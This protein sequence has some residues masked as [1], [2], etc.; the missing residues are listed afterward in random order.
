[1]DFDLKEAFW[2]ARQWLQKDWSGLIVAYLLVLI[3][4]F[5]AIWAVMEPFGIPA[6]VDVNRLPG[7]TK[8]RVFFHIILALIVSAYITLILELLCRRKIWTSCKVAYQ[9]HVEADA[10][11]GWVSDGTIAG[12]TGEDRRMEAIRIKLGQDVPPGMG[13]TYQAHVEG[14]GWTDW[15]SDGEDAGTTGLYKRLEAIRV[16]LTNAPSGYSIFYQPYV[17][18]HEWMNWV[19][20]GELAGTVGERRRLEAIRILVVSP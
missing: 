2:K 20:D 5:F 7:F 10:W 18:G 6:T 12:S 8:R 4:V 11:L 13:V 16:R 9:A 17:E 15:V 14:I 1:M 3:V 19:S